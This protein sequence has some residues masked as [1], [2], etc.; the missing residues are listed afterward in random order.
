MQTF[1][2]KYNFSMSLLRMTFAYRPSCYLLYG[3]IRR[4]RML[5]LRITRSEE[6]G[7]TVLGKGEDI[8]IRHDGGDGVWVYHPPFDVLKVVG[9]ENQ[10]TWRAWQMLGIGLGRR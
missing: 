10:E 1:F 3:T 4:G 6:K 5:R 2:T 7:V 8:Q 9:N